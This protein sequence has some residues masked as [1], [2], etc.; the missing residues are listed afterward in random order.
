MRGI[1]GLVEL[2]ILALLIA[3]LVFVNIAHYLLGWA[4]LAVVEGQSM[5]PLLLGGDVVIV[6]PNAK[7]IGLGDVII[8]KNDRDEY[9]IHRV[10]GII[11][12]TNAGKLLYMTKGDN[13]QFVDQATFIAIKT[14][15]PCPTGNLTLLKTGS[16]AFDYG[17]ISAVSDVKR[18]IDSSRIVGK[19]LQIG[20]V[21][22][23]ITGLLVH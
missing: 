19:V 10:V 17:V 9:V 20:K 1:L 8:F 22:I 18:G 13:N 11:N 14:S 3:L 12:C 5:E 15:I 4:F 16:T 7:S 2:A 21:I 6:I 23:K